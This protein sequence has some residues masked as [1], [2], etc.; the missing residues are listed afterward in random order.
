VGG[1][2]LQQQQQQQQQLE[3]D[4]LDPNVAIKASRGGVRTRVI[5]RSAVL[6]PWHVLALERA[7]PEMQQVGGLVVVV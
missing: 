1:R 2:L 4:L 5:G 3:A 7:L 6:E